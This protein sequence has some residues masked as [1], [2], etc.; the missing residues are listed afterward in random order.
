MINIGNTIPAAFPVLYPIRPA[1]YIYVGKNGNDSTG[2]GSGGNPYL[3]IGAAITS[4]TS[5]TTLFIWPGTYTE[6]ITFKAGVYIEGSIPYSVYIT[7]NHTANFSGTVICQNIIL[8]NASSVGSGSTLT[9]S[10]SSSQNLQF[11]SSYINSG[12]TSGAGD[13]V[14]YTNTNSSSKIQIIDGNIN[15][16]HSNST[17]RAIA[18]ASTA[19]GSIIANRCSIVLDNPDNVAVA[20]A[21][22][23]AYTH[24]MDK[25]IGQVTA[26]N[27]ASVTLGVLLIQT[28]TVPVLNTTSSGTTGVADVTVNTTASP[29]FIGTGVALGVA[30]NYIGTGVGG[31]STLNGGLGPIVSPLSSIKIRDAPLVPS[32]QISAGLNSG[33]FEFDGTHLYF[34]IGTTRST[35]I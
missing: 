10:G 4:A 5:G 33:A 8:Q 7:G 31:S 32:G 12:S 29:C 2:D 19:A 35:I 6:N 1:N 17:A 16:A 27:S 15:V 13:A 34:T 3:T 22:S 30:I 26:A 25:I 23:I 28:N 18:C 24:T 14:T 11:L 21:G 9:F 20:V